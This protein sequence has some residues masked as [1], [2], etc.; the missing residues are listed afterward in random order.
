MGLMPT[1]I[2]TENKE[3]KTW[4]TRNTREVTSELVKKQRKIGRGAV[5]K[6]KVN[7]SFHFGVSNGKFKGKMFASNNRASFFIFSSSEHH[8]PQFIVNPTAKLDEEVTE[9]H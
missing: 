2:Q 5:N 6:T 8:L 9:T 7:F 1:K 4:N 3:L